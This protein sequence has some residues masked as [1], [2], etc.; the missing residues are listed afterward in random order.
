MLKNKKE[1]LRAELVLTPAHSFKKW[2]IFIL[3][4]YNFR[5]L[6]RSSCSTLRRPLC[7]VTVIAKCHTH[8]QNTSVSSWV[9]LSLIQRGDSFTV[10]A[11]DSSHRVPLLCIRM[12]FGDKCGIKDCSCRKKRRICSELLLHVRKTLSFFFVLTEESRRAK[13][14]TVFCIAIGPGKTAWLIKEKVQQMNVPLVI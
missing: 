4:P 2:Q 12:S 13:S 1:E 10:S 6:C 8:T 5:V 14:L 9:Y 11:R 3:A 7:A